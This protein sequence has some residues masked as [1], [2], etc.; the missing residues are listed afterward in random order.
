VVEPEPA[1]IQASINRVAQEAQ[2][3]MMT[4]YVL[5][6]LGKMLKDE[7]RRIDLVVKQPEKDRFIILCPEARSEEVARLISRIQMSSANHLGLSVACGMATFPEEAV[8]FDD[9][10]QQAEQ[11]LQ[12]L[13]RSNGYGPTPSLQASD[14]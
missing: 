5:T 4:R 1:S 8:T 12:G 7:L 11:K 13:I 6:S 9:L 10:I 3:K 14:L 2:Q